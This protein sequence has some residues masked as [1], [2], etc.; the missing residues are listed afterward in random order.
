MKRPQTLPRD[1][2]LVRWSGQWTDS[3]L[4]NNEQFSL[5]GVDTVR[6]YLEAETLGDSGFAGGPR[7][8]QP[9]GRRAPDLSSHP[10]MP[11]FSS[12]AAS[13]PGRSAAGATYRTHLWSTGVGL[14]L[15][16]A[17]GLSGDL[18][19]AVPQVDG[20]RT[21]DGGRRIDFSLSIES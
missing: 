3:P 17:S 18:D 11:S 9:A 21:R 2:A 14:R 20:T 13:P 5:G 10:S 7:I 1:S 16:N 19:Y 8:A 12:T 4:V 6:G 15:E